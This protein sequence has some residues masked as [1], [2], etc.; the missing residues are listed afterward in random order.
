MATRCACRNTCVVGVWRR[1]RRMEGKGEEEE[2][3]EKG[4]KKK[5]TEEVAGASHQR[6]QQCRASFPFALPAA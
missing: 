5:Q 2:Q 3:K 1:V 4:K 6:T